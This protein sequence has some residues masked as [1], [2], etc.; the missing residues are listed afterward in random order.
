LKNRP[1]AGG[2]RKMPKQA[3][4]TLQFG[5]TREGLD[6]KIILWGKQVRKKARNQGLTGTDNYFP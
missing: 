1:V 6:V 3:R 2:I 4:E 5:G